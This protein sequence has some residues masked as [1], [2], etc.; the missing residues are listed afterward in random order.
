LTLDAWAA[1][2][3]DPLP[4]RP[5]AIR[6]LIEQALTGQAKADRRTRRQPGAKVPDW[7]AEQALAS[8]PK[9]RR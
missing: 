8:Q 1:A 6:R 2:Q 5:E 4:S 9:K 7:L 3:G